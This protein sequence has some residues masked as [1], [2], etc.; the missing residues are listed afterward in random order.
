MIH[1]NTHFWLE[2]ISLKELVKHHLNTK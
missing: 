2:H 1:L